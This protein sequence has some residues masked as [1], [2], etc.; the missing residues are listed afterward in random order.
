MIILFMETTVQPERSSRTAEFMA[1]FRALES[2]RPAE[3]ALFHDP[4]AA[5]FISPS[6]RRLVRW[7]ATPIVGGL[8]CTFID[9][10]WPG[11]RETCVSSS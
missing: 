1:L 2:E 4:F 5:G 7:S 11:E 8:L 9:R 3:D 6:L 10:R